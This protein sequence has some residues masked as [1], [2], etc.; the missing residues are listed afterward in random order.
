MIAICGFMIYNSTQ[1]LREVRQL[2]M[3]LI[4][5]H[6]GSA[7]LLPEN[8]ME[9]FR[10]AFQLGAPTIEFDVHLSKDGVPVII[11]DATLPRTTDG[12]G[13]VSRLTLKELEKFDAGYFFDPD[14]TG[15]FPER[16]KG[17]RIPTFEAMLAEFK[18]QNLC[19][20]IKDSSE[21]T[22]RK[23]VTLLKK[24]GAD[25]RAVVGSKHWI[26]SHTMKENYP[27]IKRFLSK[28]EFVMHYLNYKSGGTTIEKD[29][30]AVA[31]MP[32]EACGLAFGNKEFIDY[33]HVLGI[34]AFYWTINNPLVMKELSK[35]GADG[36][37]TDNPKLG[38]ETLG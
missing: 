7:A 30:R 24:Y 36:I 17:H 6:R 18:T 38:V 25:D 1:L 29:P 8:T 27:E 37:I 32:L 11:H 12:K 15:S 31:S 9:S 10:L 22:T 34:S 19:V 13:Y 33:L 16:G 23:T 2:F 20:E 4:I 3:T 14:K 35:R 28:K 5:G 26:V 21:E